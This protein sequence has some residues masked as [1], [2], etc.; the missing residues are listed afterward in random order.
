MAYNVKENSQPLKR[1]KNVLSRDNLVKTI[2]DFFEKS[3]LNKNQR[4]TDCSIIDCLMSG[5]AVFLFKHASL[6][7]FEG[8]YSCPKLHQNLKSLMK[9][10][11]IPSDTSMRYHLDG[12][13]PDSIK[14]VFRNI[15][16]ELRRNSDLSDY[17]RPDG[18][19]LISID[20]T[21]FFSSKKV[22]CSSCLIKNH[23]NGSK[24]YHHQIVTAV[25]IS[26]TRKEVFPLDCEEIRSS[27]GNT[28]NDCEQNA[29][30]RLLTRLKHNYVKTKFTV[31][32]DGLSSNAPNIELLKSLGF[33]FI[34]V[35]KD[36]NHKHLLKEHQTRMENN[37][38]EIHEAVD[39]KGLRH[40][41]LFDNDVLLN[42]SNNT[43]VN[44]VCYWTED[45]KGQ[46]KYFN[47]WVT[48]DNLSS[49]SVFEICKSGRTYWRIENETHNTLKNQGYAFEHNYGHGE[50][51]LPSVFIHL[52]LL[53]FLIDQI[54]Q[55][56]P[57]FQ[58]V[59]KKVKSKAMVWK[60]NFA[61]MVSTPVE[62]FSGLY[63]AIYEAL[64]PEEI[65][66]T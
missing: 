61:L 6:L 32:A 53:A 10:G 22:H 41:A 58:V 38:T 5:L 4:S 27:D 28:K 44:Y 62:S 8:A 14:P 26:P 24:T 3:P 17:R 47:T 31:T 36:G 33:G 23:K 42:A 48:G 59:L 56:C 13:D 18:S 34:L 39:E 16:N 40:F 35:A 37:S 43:R 21:Q 51:N 12:I 2:R 11:K 45:L 7:K 57:K 25:L 30:K 46:R 54:N 29:T 9:I 49:D 63:D 1:R 15:F 52:L 60:F 20:G 50:K 19:F 55:N 66:S 65:N 64:F